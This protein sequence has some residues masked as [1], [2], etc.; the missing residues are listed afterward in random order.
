MLGGLPSRSGNAPRLC[1][2]LLRSRRALGK[3]RKCGVEEAE[4]RNSPS[5]E[6][7]PTGPLPFV[8]APSVSCEE[9][10]R[11][12]VLGPHAQHR[13]S[14][15]R[16]GRIQAAFR[17]AGARPRVA[18]EAFTE[19]REPGARTQQQWALSVHGAKGFCSVKRSHVY[20]A[21]AVCCPLYTPGQ[22]PSLSLCSGRSKSKNI[23]RDAQWSC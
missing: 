12:L 2:R 3:G 16:P 14:R 19:V 7:L 5:C 23:T 18:L 6:P 17:V 8:S 11:A 13:I 9:S 4:P 10:D 15:V 22:G 1:Q 21:C 20:E